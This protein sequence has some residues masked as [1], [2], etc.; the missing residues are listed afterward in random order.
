[1][2]Y[3]RYNAVHTAQCRMPYERCRTGARILSIID[4]H[5][6]VI[7]QLGENEMLIYLIKKNVDQI[8]H[9][10][11]F[12]IISPNCSLHFGTPCMPYGDLTFVGTFRRNDV[13][14]V[15]V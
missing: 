8:P 7:F 11:Q 6:P 2:P 13:K 12:R 9:M 3:I 5:T 4:C 14:C 15:C 10:F 1:M